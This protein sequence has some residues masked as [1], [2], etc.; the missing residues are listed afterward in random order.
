MPQK[1]SLTINFRDIA[2]CQQQPSGTIICFRHC[3][4][5]QNGTFIDDSDELWVRDGKILEAQKIFYEER[6]RPN[7]WVDCEGLI[8]APGFIDIQMNGA[9]GVDFTSMTHTKNG[10]TALEQLKEVAQKILAFGITAFCPT[11]ITARS[12]AYQMFLQLLNEYKS[13]TKGRENCARIIGAH[14]EGPFISPNRVGCH[15]KSLVVASLQ[16]INL[17]SVYG[18]DLSNLSYVTVAPELPGAIEAIAF[19]RQKGIEMAIGHSEASIENATKAVSAG[20][21]SITHLF[22]SMR[23]VSD[24]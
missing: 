9:F 23:P 2:L 13:E 12:E 8:L 11:V 20:A 1:P 14:F 21:K 24:N 22:N 15:P 18:L 4:L 17:N 10:K 5:F 6:K 19:F 3:R 7:L 16:N